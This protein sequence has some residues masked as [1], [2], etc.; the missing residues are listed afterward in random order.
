L[1]SLL[2]LDGKSPESLPGFFLAPL[3][4][5][6]EQ[7]LPAHSVVTNH[8]TDAADRAVPV[9]VPCCVSICGRSPFG[10]RSHSVHRSCSLVVDWNESGSDR[11]SSGSVCLSESHPPAW[12]HF[13]SVRGDTS[14]GHFHLGSRP[15]CHLGTH[16]VDRGAFV[17]S[18]LGGDHRIAA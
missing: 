13:D 1:R 4:S 2:N 14:N 15:L 5:I 6:V 17:S 8:G 9:A 12:G 3:Q 7:H 11:D 10:V 16:S 18:P